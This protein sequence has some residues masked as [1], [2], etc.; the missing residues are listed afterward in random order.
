M[1]SSYRKGVDAEFVDLTQRQLAL[2]IQYTSRLTDRSVGQ[3][4][5][6]RG[7]IFRAIQYGIELEETSLEAG[8]LI[9]QIYLL[10]EYGGYWREWIPL[11]ELACRQ[12]TVQPIQLRLQLLLGWIYHL[13]RDYNRALEIH[14]QTEA[15]ARKLPARLELANSCFYL[16]TSY[17]EKKSYVDA[18]RLAE[19]ALGLFE[20]LPGEVHPNYAGTLNTLALIFHDQNKTTLAKEYFHNAIQEWQKAD[21]LTYLARAWYNLALVSQSER[22]YPEALAHYDQAAAAIEP[23]NNLFEKS[24]III[25]RASAYSLAKDYPQAEA[26]YR[27]VQLSYLRQI[28]AR[29]WQAV[30]L[31]DLGEVLFKQ[32]K[33]A[34]AESYLRDAIVIWRE[35]QADFMLSNALDILTELYIAQKRYP[36]ALPFCQ[37]GILLTEK[38]LHNHRAKLLNQKFLAK[39]PP[40]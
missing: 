40:S 35:Q 3:L 17:Y 7:R 39:I 38:Y 9:L 6:N 5:L 37:E 1:A 21:R 16:S 19:E 29:Y 2:W 4:N 12:I 15:E 24:K 26:T 20:G 14:Q 18:Q 27:Q 25:G 32:E 22:N 28:N 34:D 8:Q 11:I 23:L 30:W 36:E 31:T 10:I 33:F 13:N